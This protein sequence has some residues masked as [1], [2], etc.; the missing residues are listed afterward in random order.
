[1]DIRGVGTWCESGREDSDPKSLVCRLWGKDPTTPVG[2]RVPRGR[3]PFFSLLSTPRPRRGPEGRLP[4]VRPGGNHDFEAPEL[5]RHR[6]V[7]NFM[8]FV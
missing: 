6:H 2:C 4:P 5:N 7:V 8:R 1:M 3:T